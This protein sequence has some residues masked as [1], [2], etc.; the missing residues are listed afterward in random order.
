[1]LRV[2]WV[3]VCLALLVVIAVIMVIWVA[4]GGLR[5]P[6]PTVDGLPITHWL[7]V[8]QGARCV[9]VPPGRALPYIVRALHAQDSVLLRAGVS[10]GL[11]HHELALLLR[12]VQGAQRHRPHCRR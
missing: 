4:A 9:G 2:G 5:R 1:M 11:C 10:G 7:E 8:G 12:G 6:E 3:G